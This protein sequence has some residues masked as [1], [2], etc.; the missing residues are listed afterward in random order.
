MKKKFFLKRAGIYLLMMLLPLT[1]VFAALIWTI[2]GQME[3]SVRQEGNQTVQAVD[4]NFQLVLSNVLYQNALLTSTTRMNTSLRRVLESTEMTY[5]DTLNITS[6]QAILNSIQQ[7]HDYIES[8]YLYI[9]GAGRY[10]SSQSGICELTG[11]EDTGWLSMYGD[12]DK[13]DDVYIGK[14][15]LSEGTVKETQVLSVFQKLLL[16]DGCIIVNINV[17]KLCAILKQQEHSQQESVYLINQNGEILASDSG[18][19]S[20]KDI[21]QYLSKLRQSGREQWGEALSEAAGGW[22]KAGAGRYLLT[23]GSY[24]VMGIYY[25]SAISSGE[26]MGRLFSMMGY[27]VVLLLAA[28]GV[29]VFLAYYNTRRSFDQITY[30]LNM[31]HEAEKGLPVEKPEGKNRDEYDVLM[32]NIVYLF[33]STNQLKTQVTENQLK[34]EQAEMTALQLQINPHFL[35]NTLWT[36]EVE[37]REGSTGQEEL[38]AMVRNISDILKYALSNP[39]EPVRLEEEILYLKKYIAIQRVRFRDQFVIYYE[40]D[41]KVMQ[42]RV[43]RLFLQPLVEN[44]FLHGIRGLGR[45]G[46]IKVSAFRRGDRLRCSV[47]DLGKGMSREKLKELRTQIRDE[48]SRGIGVTNLQRRLTLRYGEESSLHINSKEGVGTVIY[49]WIPYEQ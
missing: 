12:M 27:F 46:Y 16:A 33:L 19:Q 38:C 34:R 10:L 6:L 17:E 22:T 21:L 26:M 8:I 44:S 30:M 25:L 29:V 47:V 32:N 48:N 39:Q 42:A 13:T 28:F 31:L 37:M 7:T 41:E 24:D 20:E 14:R 1:I 35:F 9:D 11:T 23:L 4:T 43:F 5:S 3:R 36:I 49:F 2:F 15:I 45:K 40:V 18:E